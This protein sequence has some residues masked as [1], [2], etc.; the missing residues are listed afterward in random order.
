MAADRLKTKEET[1]RTREKIRVR[2]AQRHKA[3]DK[4]LPVL[5][6]PAK[7]LWLLTVVLSISFL[8]ALFQNWLHRFVLI[9]TLHH[10]PSV[11]SPPFHALMWDLL[12]VFNAL[13]LPA[14]IASHWARTFRAR[15]ER[16]RVREQR[17]ATR[18]LRNEG[19]WPPPPSQEPA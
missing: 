9:G 12:S 7:H 5:Q 6:R 1:L 15:A 10:F 11:G 3:R 17:R 2:A 19:V 4:A 13:M 18:A 16:R 14:L 8:L